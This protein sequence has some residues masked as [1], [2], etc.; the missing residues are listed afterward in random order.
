MKPSIR[1]RASRYLRV[2]L[3][4]PFVLGSRLVLRA[5][6]LYPPLRAR[7]ARSSLWAR[8]RTLDA[9]SFKLALQT[10][11]S[12]KERERPNRG[13]Q[14]EEI[15]SGLFRRH[16]RP[17]QDLGERPGTEARYPDPAAPSAPDANRQGQAAQAQ[18]SAEHPSDP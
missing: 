16:R 4:A 3:R 10:A 12:R 9:L 7:R 1:P 6:P 2:T 11:F 14:V 18:R 17:N 15:G 5:P 8:A 13:P